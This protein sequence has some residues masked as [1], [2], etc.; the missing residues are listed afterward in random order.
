MRILMIS[1]R[2]PP[3]TRSVAHLFQDLAEGL[4]KR[5]ED[6]V[7]MTKM[8][9]EHLPCDGRVRH[10]NPPAIDHLG[11]VKIIRVRGL[12][13]TN[14]SIFCRAL[15]QIYLALRVLWRAL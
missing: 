9:L 15:D 7:V 3:E 13:S 10:T 14:R 12:F 11:G 1:D 8:P 4:V 5:G 2:Y 6:V